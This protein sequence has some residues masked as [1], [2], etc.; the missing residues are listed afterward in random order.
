MKRVNH[1]FCTFPK[2]A[3]EFSA[4]KCG[5]VPDMS[6]PCV[7]CRSTKYVLDKFTKRGK[8][9]MYVCLLL[10]ARTDAQLALCA[11]KRESVSKRG[12]RIIIYFFFFFPTFPFSLFRVERYF[13]VTTAF[14]LHAID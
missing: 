2:L 13:G 5:K 1:N 11:G 3:F 10:S 12:K 6:W 9:Y 4:A 7:R 8:T 14:Y